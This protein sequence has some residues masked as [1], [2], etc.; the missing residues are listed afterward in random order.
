MAKITLDDVAA[1]M[2]N[3]FFNLHDEMQNGLH[4]VQTEMQNEFSEARHERDEIKVV[5]A[6][7]TGELRQLR[8]IVEGK[9]DQLDKHDVRISRAEKHLHLV[10]ALKTKMRP[11]SRSLFY[12]PSPQSISSVILAE[13]RI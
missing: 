8:R 4:N 13:S 9:T 1:M 12:F 10:S 11:Y 7:H 6:E 2:Q 5:Q 3:Q